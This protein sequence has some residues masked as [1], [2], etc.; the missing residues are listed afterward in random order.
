MSDFSI[1]IT[2]KAKTYL[3]SHLFANNA[4]Y[5][6]IKVQGGKCSGFELIFNFENNI[7]EKDIQFIFD[8]VIILV[9][10]KSIKFIN[11]STLDYHKSLINSGLK[12]NNPNETSRC[13]CGAS[14][15]ILK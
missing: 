9:D 4:K 2:D 11:N 6:R 12:L 1:Q 5:L 13:G 10:H 8:Q 7:E 15:D 3:Q 14:F